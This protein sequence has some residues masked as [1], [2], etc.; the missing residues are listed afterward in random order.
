[1]KLRILVYVVVL[2][3]CNLLLSREGRAQGQLEF[4]TPGNDSVKVVLI[5][6]TDN[7]RFEQK[8]S[9]TGMTY[10]VGNVRL[11]EGK[12]F[13]NCDSMVRNSRDSVLECYGHVHINDN[14][15][16]NIFSDYMKYQV[17]IRKVYFNKNVQLTDGKGTLTTQELQY[18]LNKKV[19]IY[20]HGG[21]IVNKASVLTSEEGTYF[22]DTK[23]VHFKKNVVLK[24]PQYD[25]SADSLLYNTQ[26]QVSTFIT[27]TFIQFKDST[28]RTVRTSNGYYD[29]QHRKAYFG[30]RPIITDGSQRITG[31]TVQMDDSLGISLA[32]GN[33]IY[34]DTAQGFVLQANYMINTKKNNTFLAT[35]K[36]LMTLKQDKDSIYIVA[37]TLLSGRLVDAQEAARQM[38]IADSIHKIYVDSLYKV[39]SDSLH[40]AALADT[41]D[42]QDTLISV[43]DSSHHM[44][45][46]D[47]SDSLGGKHRAPAD[48]LEA[49]STHSK[50]G[51][52]DSLGRKSLTGKPPG[53]DSTVK[54]LSR[55]ERKRQQ[56]EIVKL[57]KAAADSIQRVELK[58]QQA[59]ADSL[60]MKELT[61]TTSGKPGRGRISI[62]DSA[63]RKALAARLR[64]ADSLAAINLKQKIADSLQ[65]RIDD[66]LQ[67]KTFDSLAAVAA[68][69]KAE[70]V[71]TD[72]TLRF[73]KG[74]HHVRIYSDSLQAVGDSLYYSGKD[75]IFR[76][77]YNPIAW[78]S[79]DYQVTGDTMYV[80]TKN[81]KATRL[82]V[83]EN[84]LAINKV[85]KNFYNQ[86]KGTTINCYFK[87]GEVDYMRAKGNAE[88]IY[89]VRDDNK[90]YTGV[91]KAHADIIDMVFAAKDSGK[92]RE[93]NRVVFRSDVEGSMIPF[94][95]VNFDDMRLRGF[96]WH[97]EERPKNKEDLWKQK[98]KEDDE[99]LEEAADSTKAA[100][101]MKP[102]D[103]TK[104]DSTKLSK[105]KQST[106]STQS[107]DNKQPAGK[108]AGKVTD[109]KQSDGKILGDKPKT[110]DSTKTVDSIPP[111]KKPA[112]IKQPAGN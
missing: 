45:I 112:D 12:T 19:G 29:L 57:Q 68:K 21:K 64:A 108:S 60:T 35:Q 100:G 78:G 13:I 46:K 2:T 88:S 20:L 99:E 7:Y 69:E 94:K 66:S 92:G 93:L 51:A 11:K 48:S 5:Q 79:G 109:S 82:Y 44:R 89:Y 52:V 42:Q 105:N 14:D 110:T 30:K 56:R 38:A 53:T 62:A 27:E 107:T 98:P 111:D 76:L 24:D 95:K 87:N 34:K 26:T 61:D 70:A 65:R 1:M 63:R 6:N 83:F 77:Y 55:R 103:S 40:R 81:K 15:S 3:C 106:K 102:A 97:E 37:D 58:R 18:D 96:K 90:A 104:A 41:A 28:R 73:I 59:I 101:H 80:Y 10:L 72:T 54:Q 16:T 74:F 25:L 71:V 50:P 43:Q 9:I 86:M 8:D 23:D 39:S 67:Q 17:N 49:D 47:L 75:S 85:G 91:N 32:R 84:A 31:D 33:A 4:R 22:E 36:P